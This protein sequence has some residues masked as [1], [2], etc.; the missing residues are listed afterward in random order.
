MLEPFGDWDRWLDAPFAFAPA[1]N[2]WEDENNV[3]VEAPL[4]GVDPENVNIAIENDILT[5]EGMQ[6]KKK[7]KGRKELL[8][9]SALWFFHRALLSQRQSEA[10]S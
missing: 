8:S 7:R 2:I 9:Q 1:V 3:Y 6:E 4:P 10:R 5:I